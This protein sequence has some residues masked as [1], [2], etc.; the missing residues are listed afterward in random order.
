MAKDWGT[1]ASDQAKTA[2]RCE[3]ID[4]WPEYR[5]HKHYLAMGE[6]L[7]HPHSQFM[8]KRFFLWLL[9]QN[10]R[11]VD[12]KIKPYKQRAPGQIRHC[13]R[14][15]TCHHPNTCHHQ[16]HPFVIIVMGRS[17]KILHFWHG[18]FW[19]EGV[20]FSKHNIAI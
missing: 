6:S 12:C 13:H 19:Q 15:M 8:A 10:G 1:N 5:V 16:C 17:R 14:F 9:H 3:K 7:L 4:R 11:R 20:F 2:A 18:L